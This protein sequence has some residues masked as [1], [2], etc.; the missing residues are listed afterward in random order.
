MVVAV[1]NEEAA[2]SGPLLLFVHA[3]QQSSSARRAVP[4]QVES[5]IP[6]LH[7]GVPIRLAVRISANRP[8]PGSRYRGLT[9]PKQKFLKA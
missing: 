9:N 2:I 5:G 7:A 8:A 1:E 6:A 4:L 3:V